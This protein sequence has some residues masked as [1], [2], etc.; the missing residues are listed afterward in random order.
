LGFP[1]ANH[2]SSTKRARSDRVKSDRNSQ[3]LTS[4]RT[5]VKRFRFALAALNAGTEKDVAKVDALL[6]KAQ[7][8]LMK[9]G[10]K[11]VL[12]KKAASRRVSRLA[13]AKKTVVGAKK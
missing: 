8:M 7:E 10:S 9:A 4:V 6:S 13:L 5:A 12:H 1:V 11:G 3:Y 2:K